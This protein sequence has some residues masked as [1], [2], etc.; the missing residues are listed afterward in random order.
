MNAICTSTWTRPLT[1]HNYVYFSFNS[2]SSFTW[3]RWC[4]KSY[5]RLVSGRYSCSYTFCMINNLM[6]TYRQNGNRRNTVQPSPSSLIHWWH[7]P[8]CWRSISIE[9]MNF[10][11]H[12]TSTHARSWCISHAL[13]RHFCMRRSCNL[14]NGKMQTPKTAYKSVYVVN[15]THLSR[16]TSE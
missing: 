8:S 14:Q 16:S 2:I 11:R 7:S 5:W 3:N 6:E 9:C 13:R 4:R 15:P 10:W 1:T 12:N